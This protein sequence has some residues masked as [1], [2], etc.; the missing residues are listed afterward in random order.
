MSNVIE[1]E[2]S[3]VRLKAVISDIIDVV[4]DDIQN[5]DDVVKKEA[6]LELKKKISNVLLKSIQ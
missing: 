4:K 5:E 3:I 1:N 2:V 6:K